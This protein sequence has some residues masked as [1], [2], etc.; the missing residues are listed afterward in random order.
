MKGI[1]LDIG[2]WALIIICGSALFWEL[3]SGG[4][5]KFWKYCRAK[6]RERHCWTMWN[7]GTTCCEVDEF[8]GRKVDSRQTKRK[9]S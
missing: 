7:R 2:F 4:Q 9:A 3:V 5:K 8:Y 1:L 6:N